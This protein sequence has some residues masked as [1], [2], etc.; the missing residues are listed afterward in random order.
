[1]LFPVLR[2]PL[3]TK[4]HTQADLIGKCPHTSKNIQEIMVA[5]FC[6][7]LGEKWNLIF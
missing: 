3:N 7:S 1:M 2:P 4:M 5:F 6:S